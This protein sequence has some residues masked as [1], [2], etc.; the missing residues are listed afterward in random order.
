LMNKVVKKLSLG[1]WGWFS[2]LMK[3]TELLVIRVV[4]A[5]VYCLVITDSIAQEDYIM[6]II[7]PLKFDK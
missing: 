5:E 3:N 1:V 4:Q 6:L 2:L 7:F